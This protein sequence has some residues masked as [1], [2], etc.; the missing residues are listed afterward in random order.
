MKANRTKRKAGKR[1]VPKKAVAELLH[2][3][4]SLKRGRQED[5]WKAAVQA[6]EIQDQLDRENSQ[7]SIDDVA[8]MAVPEGRVRLDTYLAGVVQKLRGPPPRQP[9]PFRLAAPRRNPP[10]PIDAEALEAG[11]LRVM[12]TRRKRLENVEKKSGAPA[13]GTLRERTKRSAA[14]EEN[15]LRQLRE[16]KG[17]RL[18]LFNRKTGA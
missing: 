4:R 10:P 7:D 5:F 13:R 17:R 9:S 11:M 1:Y 15:L 2:V 6:S 8:K 12:A 16:Q 14:L 3:V 18:D